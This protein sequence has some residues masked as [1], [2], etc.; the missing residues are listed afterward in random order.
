MFF[1][2]FFF[3]FFVLFLNVCGLYSLKSP[4]FVFPSAFHFLFFLCVYAGLC[5]GISDIL[6]FNLEKHRRCQAPTRNKTEIGHIHTNTT[7]IYTH[8]HTH[9]YIYI[10]THAQETKCSGS[11]SGRI[12]PAHEG[13]FYY[14]QK[15]KKKTTTKVILLHHISFFI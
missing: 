1:F 14:T 8:T 10:H 7:H 2:S 5:G 3:F 12:D 13:L 4:I 11:L 6:S 9:I 15:D